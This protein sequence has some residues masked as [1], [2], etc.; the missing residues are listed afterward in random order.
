MTLARREELRVSDCPRTF[1]AN[2]DAVLQA[3]FH[4]QLL[5]RRKTAGY[6]PKRYAAFKEAQRRTAVGRRCGPARHE[7]GVATDGR[8][9]GGKMLHISKA[10]LP[11]KQE[12]TLFNDLRH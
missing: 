9:R 3:S 8:R 7:E 12:Q 2:T 6:C 5:I 4:R 11:M 1:T 10:F